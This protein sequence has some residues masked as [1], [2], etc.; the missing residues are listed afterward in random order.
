MHFPQVGLS[1]PVSVLDASQWVDLP[2]VSDPKAAL[3]SGA[4]VVKKYKTMSAA[5]LSQLLLRA[6]GSS[7]LQG[8]CQFSLLSV[9]SG[10][11]CLLSK[12]SAHGLLRAR[13][14][15]LLTAW[16]V[17]RRSRPSAHSRAVGR[18]HAATPGSEPKA[19]SEALQHLS[20]KGCHAGV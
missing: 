5:I 6:R 9:V 7:L 18:T 13:T 19:L 2:P 20:S 12:G 16:P 1:P 10:K 15:W 4:L 3:P 8:I 17:A 11:S 14:C